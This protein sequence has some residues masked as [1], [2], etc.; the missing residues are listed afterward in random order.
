MYWF[1]LVTES[2]K[3][4]IDYNT[5]RGWPEVFQSSDD[6]KDIFFILLRG[7]LD[8]KTLLPATMHNIKKYNYVH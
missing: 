5:I 7:V 1:V 6:A 3:A 4:K 2:I 8:L